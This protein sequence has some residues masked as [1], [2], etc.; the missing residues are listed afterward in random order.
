MLAMG[1][2]AHTAQ[3]QFKDAL[4]KAKNAVQ[5]VTDGD[6]TQDEI[7]SG[8]KEALNIGVSEASSVCK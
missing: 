3:A 5:A 2:L 7:G 8:L 4:N 6:L 1:L